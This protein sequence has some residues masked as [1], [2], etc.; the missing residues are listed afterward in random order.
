MLCRE[1]NWFLIFLFLVHFLEPSKLN[2]YFQCNIQVREN[3]LVE[4]I[5]LEAQL[6]GFLK[7]KSNLFL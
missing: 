4:L 3:S 7:V 2:S 6:Y 5:S 1:M